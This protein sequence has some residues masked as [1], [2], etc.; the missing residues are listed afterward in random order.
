VGATRAGECA[1]VTQ[2]KV[3]GVTVTEGGVIG[4]GPPPPLP[5]Q[6]EPVVVSREAA[7]GVV[8]LAAGRV[9]VDVE[10][11]EVPAFDVERG[12]LPLRGLAIEVAGRKGRVALCGS[13]AREGL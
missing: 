12:G 4:A 8:R 1:V 3:L 10:A 7:D 13:P 2:G 9:P 5:C 11:A 6:P